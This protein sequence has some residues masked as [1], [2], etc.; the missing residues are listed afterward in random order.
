MR[1]LLAAFLF[2][3]LSVSPATAVQW[4]E[5]KIIYPK[6]RPSDV[7]MIATSAC[8]REGV[9]TALQRALKRFDN[10]EPGLR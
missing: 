8:G 10:P 6:D 1:Y 3:P 5:V 7:S 2:L 9:Q 4:C